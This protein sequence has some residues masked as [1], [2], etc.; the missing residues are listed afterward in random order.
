ME[1]TSLDC[2][3]IYTTLIGTIILSMINRDG[4]WIV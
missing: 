1:V 3:L 2:W 4:S